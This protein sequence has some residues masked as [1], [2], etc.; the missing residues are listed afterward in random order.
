MSVYRMS[1]LTSTNLSSIDL[2]AGTVG[3]LVGKY[4]YTIVPLCLEAGSSMSRAPYQPASH[5]LCLY[6]LFHALV[7][8]HCQ[9]ALL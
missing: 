6:E 3:A 9:Y 2:Q 1:G 8:W 5:T 7:V 4:L